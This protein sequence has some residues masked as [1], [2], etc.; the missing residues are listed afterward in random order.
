M[1]TWASH[2]RKCM[3]AEDTELAQ[4]G[5]QKA[6]DTARAGH[7]RRGLWVADT[8]PAWA[9][10]RLGSLSS[11]LATEGGSC[12][13]PLAPYILYT[14]HKRE[15]T[16]W[17]IRRKLIHFHALHFSPLYQPSE[18]IASLEHVHVR[19]QS[20]VQCTVC[21][22]KHWLYSVNIS[23]LILHSKINYWIELS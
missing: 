2:W 17:L 1:L 11:G 7:W 6:W 15:T 23:V 9:R 8:K 12:K 4:A 20:S 10:G 19:T 3:W 14:R 16:Y 5:A 13:W 21:T 22:H 18:L